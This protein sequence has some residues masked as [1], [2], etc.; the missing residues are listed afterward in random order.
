A[1][2]ED[3]GII[4]AQLGLVCQFASTI[5]TLAADIDVDGNGV[6]DAASVGVRL[7]WVGA[8]IDEQA[9]DTE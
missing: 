5:P 2:G 4:C 8:S 3:D 9:F 7:G 6:E 1:C